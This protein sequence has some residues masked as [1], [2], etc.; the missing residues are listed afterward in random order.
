MADG[1]DELMEELRRAQRVE[2]LNERL[3]G[4]DGSRVI[5]L[6]G[7]VPRLSEEAKEQLKV[8]AGEHCG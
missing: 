5:G 6:K 2:E 8:L 7:R 1:E 4:R 3:P